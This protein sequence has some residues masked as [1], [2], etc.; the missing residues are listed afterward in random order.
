MTTVAASG[1]AA[2]CP[3]NSCTPCTLNGTTTITAH[4][5]R[6]P[7]AA[8]I[9]CIASAGANPES[10]VRSHFYAAGDSITCCHLVG[11]GAQLPV[12]HHVVVPTINNDT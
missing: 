7:G 1:P 5:L 12:A 10:D 9:T 2:A 11:Q 3:F 6:A 4:R 8:C